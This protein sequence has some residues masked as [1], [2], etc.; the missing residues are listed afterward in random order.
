M[1]FPRR[2]SIPS[3]AVL[4]PLLSLAVATRASA[5]T[6]FAVTATNVTVSVSGSGVTSY[7][8]TGIPMTGSL[9]MSCQYSGSQTIK[10]KIPIC[11]G[12]VADS[13]AVT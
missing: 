12:A 8:V 10:A 6:P 11:A 1:R 5:S 9:I 3:L 7:T 13:I 2:I 4:F